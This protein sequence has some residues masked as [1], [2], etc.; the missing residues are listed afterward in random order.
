MSSARVIR[1]RQAEAG[2]ALDRSGGGRPDCATAMLVQTVQVTAYPVVAAA[3]YAC[4]PC[5]LN[6]GE[7]EAGTATPV[8]DTTTTFC[9]LNVGTQIPPLGTFLLVHGVGGR[10]VARYDG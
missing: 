3:Y 2:A 9:F 7:I 10:M 4:N 8:A 1:D 6:G 5:Q